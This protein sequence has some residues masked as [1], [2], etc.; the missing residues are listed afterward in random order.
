[1]VIMHRNTSMT[2]TLPPV[3]IIGSNI[4]QV[5]ETIKLLTVTLNS[6]LSWKEHVSCLTKSV[7]Y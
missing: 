1:M 5:V 3:L 4:L 7:S 2:A 6:C